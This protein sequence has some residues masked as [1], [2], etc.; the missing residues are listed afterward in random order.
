MIIDYGK[1]VASIYRA[2]GDLIEEVYVIITYNITA[3]LAGIG[4]SSLLMQFPD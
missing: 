4:F 1:T 2:Y 3:M